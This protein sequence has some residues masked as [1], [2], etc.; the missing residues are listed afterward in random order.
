M[1][2]ANENVFGRRGDSA[3]K[4]KWKKGETRVSGDWRQVWNG[5]KWVSTRRVDK[6][7]PS[8]GGGT[9]NTGGTGGSGPV[10]VGPYDRDYLTASQARRE[11]ERRALEA[12]EPISAI[13]A[14]AK[15][16]LAGAE[17]IGKTFQQMLMQQQA[18]NA[19]VLQAI[20]GGGTG[21]G[22]ALTTGALTGALQEGAYAPRY[23]AG[24]T[25]QSIRGVQQRESE[26]RQRRS[27][28]FRKY[29]AQAGADIREEEKEKQA[30]RIERDI[31]DKTFGLK[32]AEAE[33]NA[34]ES[35]RNYELAKQRV[36]ISFANSV[37]SGEK[38]ILRM[39]DNA[40]KSAGK[41]AGKRGTGL[42][43]GSISYLDANNEWQT[44]NIK[45]PVRLPKD[46]SKAARDKFWANYVK[47]ARGV[48]PS[49]VDRSGLSEKT[50]D[51]VGNPDAI[52]NGLFDALQATGLSLTDAYNYILRS[53]FGM[54]NAA[55][56]RRA[57][58][59]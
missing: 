41:G 5:K 7:E 30:A 47:K 26:A 36:E 48:V 50:T 40:A 21:A 27:E 34:M 12:V 23:A 9:G 56:V 20:G 44:I 24:Q 18:Q 52:A 38:D 16:E 35:D 29:L 42:W 31:A 17:A 1:A 51:G 43:S 22:S 37:T 25:A 11:Q 28:D 19:A 6:D 54:A 33:R 2:V 46:N 15:R 39:I 32:L 55:A 14:R 3:S 4:T 10:V 8:S 53:A 49:S 58:E 45:N 13:E 59:G 57:Y